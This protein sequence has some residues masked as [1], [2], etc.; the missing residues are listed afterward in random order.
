MRLHE[1]V[2]DYRRG[3]L[4]GGVAGDELVAGAVERMAALGVVRPDRWVD[5][6]APGAWQ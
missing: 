4:V 1:A 3:E 6:Y 2:A 5:V